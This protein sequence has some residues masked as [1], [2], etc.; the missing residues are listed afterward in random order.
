M[1]LHKYGDMLYEGLR[2]EV[3]EHLC[4]VAQSIIQASD[5]NFL[6]VLNEAWKDHEVSMIMI[7]DI[8]MYMVTLFFILFHPPSPLSFYYDVK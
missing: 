8:L 5:H 6:T 1:V 4:W 7:R 3:N 2:Q